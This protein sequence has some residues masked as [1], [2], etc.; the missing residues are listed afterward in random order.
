MFRKGRMDVTSTTGSAQHALPE[1][2]QWQPSPAYWLGM[3]EEAMLLDPADWSLAGSTEE[4]LT[5]FPPELAAQMS[6]ETHDAALE[7]TTAP[8]ASA[9]AVQAEAARLRAALRDGLLAT[10][11]RAAVSGTHPFAVW[12]DVHVSRGAR[13]QLVYE[14]MRELARREPTF[15]LHV[16][17]GVREPEAAL[18]LL[19]QVRAHIPLLLALSSNSPYWQGRDSGLA[20]VRTPIFQVF[21]RVG[22]PRAFASYA[23]YVEV[24][25][26]LI[27]CQAIPEPTFLWWDVRLQP[28]LGTV[29]VRIMDAQTTVARSGGLAA[30]VQA[31]AHLELEEGY[32]PPALVHAQ[33]ILGEN[34]FLAARD[35]MDAQLIDLVSEHKVAARKCLADLL[36]AVRPHAQEL[37]CEPALECVEEMAALTGAEWQRRHARASD[38]TH[39]VA[40]LSAAF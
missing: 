3:E 4:L 29:E 23:E 39:L 27:R 8:H 15:A 14:S 36:H 18:G 26:Q 6:A 24:V 31:I 25:D 13:Y 20:S 16:H 12:R 28:R 22:I 2:A 9:A 17:V 30:L 5:G 38:L 34:R 35:G 19:N 7:L 40:D 11:L 10:G 32:H 21:P 37:G 1:W 33:E